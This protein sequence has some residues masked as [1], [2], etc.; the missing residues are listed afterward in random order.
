MERAR[1]VFTEMYIILL[2]NLKKYVLKISK[3]HPHEY[4]ED[5]QSKNEN[6]FH[7]FSQRALQTVIDCVPKQRVA[8]AIFT[9]TL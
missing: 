4:R 2:Q 9:K 5:F 7:N 6:I 3:H 1:Q 8:A